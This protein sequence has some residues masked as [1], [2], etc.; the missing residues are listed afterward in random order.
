MSLS[1]F[2]Q[3]KISKDYRNFLV[4]DLQD[5][6]IGINTKQNVRRKI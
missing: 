3:E 2:Y 4:K 6:C 5:Q 1:S